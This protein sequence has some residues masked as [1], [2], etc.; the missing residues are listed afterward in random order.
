MEDQ[1]S[2]RNMPY[3]SALQRGDSCVSSNSPAGSSGA[4]RAIR[5]GLFRAPRCILRRNVC[6]HRDVR[7]VDW[8]WKESGAARKNG[9]FQVRPERRCLGGAVSRH[10]KANQ[11]QEIA[12]GGVKSPGRGP[13]PPR[14]GD[15]EARRGMSECLDRCQ[16]PAR[17]RGRTAELET[18]SGEV[19]E[20]RAKEVELK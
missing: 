7:A 6:L 4:T 12:A 11:R 20:R 16:Q 1:G 15:S 8:K 19:I 14:R 17:Y 10:C 18:P 9:L 13:W 5:N 3:E 2:R